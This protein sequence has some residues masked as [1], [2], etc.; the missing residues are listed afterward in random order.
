M[1]TSRLLAALFT[2]AAVLGTPSSHAQGVYK[3][4]DAGG[5]THYGSQPPATD[6]GG[7]TLKLHSNSG[8]GGDNNGKAR[9]TEYNAD[10]TKKLPKDAAD[11]AKGFEKSLKKVDPSNE[12]LNC[13]K[14][15]ENIRGQADTMLEV[16]EQNMKGGYIT[17]ADY[18]A[19]SVKIRQARTETTQADCQSAT[20]KKKAFYQCM[21]SDYNHIVGC[22]GK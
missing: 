8:F 13:T 3:W 15:V 21:T 12:P 2:C 22:G 18:D 20:G 5:K 14:A 1:P 6:K 4:V 17:Q 7:E 9:A 16:G 10:G 11:L 19:Q